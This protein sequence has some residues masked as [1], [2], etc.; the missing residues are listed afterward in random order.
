VSEILRNIRG[1]GFLLVIYAS[2]QDWDTVSKLKT[3]A[4]VDY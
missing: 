1:L 3:Y 4:I 2:C